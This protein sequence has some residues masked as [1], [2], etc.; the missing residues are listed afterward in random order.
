MLNYVT[1]VEDFVGL[2]LK[3]KMK[4]E[5]KRNVFEERLNLPAI[6]WEIS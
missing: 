5:E 6:T 1:V 4:H 3:E 2:K